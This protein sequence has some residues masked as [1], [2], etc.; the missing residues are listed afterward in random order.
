MTNP[1]NPTPST[2]IDWRVVTENLTGS[3]RNNLVGVV[4]GAAEDIEEYV[5]D[6]AIDMT[7]VLKAGKSELDSELRAQ[8]RLVAELNRIRIANA[9]SAIFDQ[10]ITAA[11]GFVSSL[12]AS[13]ASWLRTAGT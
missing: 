12:L 6:I 10:I 7:R 5:N 13:A 9:Q 8:L 2:R 11:L 4:E 3:L 1:T